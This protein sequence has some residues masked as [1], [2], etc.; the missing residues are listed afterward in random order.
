MG[1]GGRVSLWSAAWVCPAFYF[2]TS[3]VH[4]RSLPKSLLLGMHMPCRAMHTGSLHW[5]LLHGSL[6]L[7][8]AASLRSHVQLD[9]AIKQIE[10]CCLPKSLKLGMHMQCT[11]PAL[12]CTQ[13][14]CNGPWH[15]ALDSPALCPCFDQEPYEYLWLTK[16]IEAGDVLHAAALPGNCGLGGLHGD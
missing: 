15:A 5:P 7:C 13:S 3:H 14:A 4:I 12:Q 11:C 10:A 9:K 8:A 6:L 1:G 2:P 16:V